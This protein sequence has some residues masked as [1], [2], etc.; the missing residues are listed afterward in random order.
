[1]A[2]RDAVGSQ[3]VLAKRQDD[4]EAGPA[5]ELDDLVDQLNDLDI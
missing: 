5:D 2:G 4:I 3:A 1:M